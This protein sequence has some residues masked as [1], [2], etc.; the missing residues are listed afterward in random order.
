M[1]KYHFHLVSPQIWSGQVGIV[2]VHART[3]YPRGA[4]GMLSQKN[5]E[6]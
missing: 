3:L 5:F 4:G 2:R 6:I 1:M